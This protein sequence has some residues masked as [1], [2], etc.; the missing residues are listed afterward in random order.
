MGNWDKLVEQKIKEAMKQGE[1]DNL[2]GKGKPINLDENPFEDPTMRT[3]Y[4]LLK[5]NNFSLPWIEERK[6]LDASVEGALADLARSWRAYQESRRARRRP[7][8]QAESDWQKVLGN[9]RRQ[10]SDLNRRIAAYNLRAPST[11]FH[12]L[13]VDAEREIN[14]LA[15]RA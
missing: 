10:V 8:A 11:T 13:P 12:R 1:F 6:D 5:N 7:P 4:R 9:F 3:A 14:K 2:P 15:D